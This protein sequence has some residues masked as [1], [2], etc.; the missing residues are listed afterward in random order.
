M[1]FTS[2]CYYRYTFIIFT[3]SP[4]W[5]RILL[6]MIKLSSYYVTRFVES[7]KENYSL[8]FF[9]NISLFYI[10]H[11][12]DLRFSK[13]QVAIAFTFLENFEILLDLITIFFNFTE[14]F[15]TNVEIMFCHL[16]CEKYF[17]FCTILDCK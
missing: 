11:F 16:F 1:K 5:Q 14:L 2:F 9:K 13:L 8:L 3:C 7:I 15:E 4:I 17:V 12:A 10:T 6:I